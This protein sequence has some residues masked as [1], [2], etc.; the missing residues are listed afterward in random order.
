MPLHNNAIPNTQ[1]DERRHIRETDK[2]RTTATNRRLPSN[3]QTTPPQMKHRQRP[4]STAKEKPTTPASPKRCL[5]RRQDAAIAQAGLGFSPRV[6]VGW[7]ERDLDEA[8]KEGYRCQGR[9]RHC[10]HYQPG[11]SPDLESPTT[12]RSVERSGRGTPTSAVGGRDLPRSSAQ[13]TTDH[14]RHAHRSPPSHHPRGRGRGPTLTAAARHVKETTLSPPPGAT[15]PASTAPTK[16]AAG[17][18]SP[19]LLR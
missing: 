2:L 17:S 1:A 14:D 3:L 9:Q 6:G 11:V 13:P 19:T 7:G 4:P 18:A 16:G 12:I 5:K 15:A 10:G 8:S